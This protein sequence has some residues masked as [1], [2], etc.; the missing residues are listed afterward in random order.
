MGRLIPALCL[1][2]IP[3]DK[4]R[5]STEILARFAALIAPVM[6]RVDVTQHFYF[7]PNRILW[8]NWEKWI[9]GQYEVDAPYFNTT[10]ITHGSIGDYLGLPTET[11]QT[12]LSVSAFPTAAY[13]KIYDEYYRDQNLIAE[14]FTELTDGHNLAYAARTNW[15]PLKRA[16]EHDYFTSALPW[17]Q[18]GDAALI[19][20]NESPIEVEYNAASQSTFWKQK[21]TDSKVGAADFYVLSRASNQGESAFP[22]NTGIQISYDPNGT[23]EIPPAGSDINSL[24]RA[25]RLQEWLE[26][27]ARGGTRYIE[28]IREH[29]GVISSDARLQRPEYIG[30][31]KSN[32]VISEVLSTTETTNVPVG[33]TAG[34]GIAVSGSDDIYYEAEEH[35]YIISILNVQPRTAYQQGI[36]RKFSRKTNLDYAWPTFAE[37]GEQEVYT[38]ELYCN[39]PDQEEIFGYMPRYSEYKIENSRVAGDFKTSLSYWHLGRI[40][41]I[42]Q[43]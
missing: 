5:I 12:A 2:V 3:G 16:W 25:F 1:E 24:R 13:L 30:G 43:F 35:G 7:V 26:K 27:N 8:N 14:K 40:L 17:Q 4:F 31:A 9:T 34:H 29:F 21:G 15:Y 38:K 20:L 28:H 6:H 23:L 18:K 22:P 36:P 32:M 42:S 37:L 33:Q 10:Y 11:I 39:I 19:P 41:I